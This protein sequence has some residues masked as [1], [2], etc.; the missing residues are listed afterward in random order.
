MK[1]QEINT[2]DEARQYAIDWQKWASEQS[3]SYGELADWQGIF[4]KLADKFD[5]RAEFEENAII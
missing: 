1:L 5:L 3:L 2:K 4:T